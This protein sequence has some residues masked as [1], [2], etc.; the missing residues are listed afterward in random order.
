MKDPKVFILHIL[1]AIEAIQNYIYGY[2]KSK[3]EADA[4][5]QDAVI[6]RLEVIR[7]PVVS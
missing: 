2:D 1:E 3:F 6:R 7:K 4:K 5:T